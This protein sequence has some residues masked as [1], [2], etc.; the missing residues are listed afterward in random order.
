MHDVLAHLISVHM[1]RRTVHFLIPMSQIINLY[2]SLGRDTE[3]RDPFHGINQ[4]LLLLCAERRLLVQLICCLLDFYGSVWVSRDSAWTTEGAV[5]RFERLKQATLP[6]KDIPFHG[7][8][9]GGGTIRCFQV[10]GTTLVISMNV[11]VE[12]TEIFFTC[13]FRDA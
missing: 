13:G 12:S 6:E 9:D 8:G 7:E 4:E 10:L 3:G 2:L 1:E 11:R 5:S